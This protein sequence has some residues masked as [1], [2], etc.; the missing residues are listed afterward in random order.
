MSRTPRL[1]NE[2]PAYAPPLDSFLEV[3][4]VNALVNYCAP[5]LLRRRHEQQPII[6]VIFSQRD[7]FEVGPSIS[8]DSIRV[9]LI[10][11]RT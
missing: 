6:R 4:F 2:K 9:Q 11:I 7:R 8:A 5:T 1:W 3:V 10:R